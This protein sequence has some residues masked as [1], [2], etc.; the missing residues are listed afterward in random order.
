MGQPG[1]RKGDA[2]QKESAK[3]ARRDV[4]R[5]SGRTPLDART[6]RPMENPD[7]GRLERPDTGGQT[8]NA[9]RQGLA[10]SQDKEPHDRSS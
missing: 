8:D 10:N 5:V 3:K 7:E 1:E 4:D 2:V 6:G 9:D